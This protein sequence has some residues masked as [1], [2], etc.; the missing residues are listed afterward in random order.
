[1][2]SAMML[3]AACLAFAIGWLPQAAAGLLEDFND[4]RQAFRS[5]DPVGLKS[6]SERLHDTPLAIYARYWPLAIELTRPAADV[7]LDEAGLREFFRDY[8]S[9]WLSDRLR[10]DYAKRLAR[11]GRW[12]EFRRESALVV[13]GDD[14]IN[15]YRLQQRISNNEASAL[16]EAQQLWFTGKQLPEACNPVFDTLLARQLLTREK[17]WR[18]IQLAMD[19]NQFG[20]AQYLNRIFPAGQGFD[21][22]QMTDAINK[23]AAVLEK[24][25]GSVSTR[26]QQEIALAAVGRLAR[27]DPVRAASALQSLAPELS[28][29]QQ[30]SGWGRVGFYGARKH[31][32]AALGWFGRA[33]LA[34]LVD[35]EREW[36]VRAA[37]RGYQWDTVIAV[38]RAMSPAEQADPPWRYWL[39]RALKI[40]GQ[41]VEANKLLAPLSLEHHFYGLLAREELDAVIDPP[42]T[43][44]Q[45]N[46][47]E[48]EA[49]AAQPNVQRA[50][51]LFRIEA[52]AEAVKEWNWATRKLD[53]RQ[54]IAAAELARRE[55]WYDRAIYAADRT[56]FVHDFS[57]RYLAPYRDVTRVYAA[58]VNLDDAWVYGLIRQESRFVT[59][60][61][62]GVGASG[63]MQ[64]M[65]TTAAWVARKLGLRDY[66]P[67]SVNE[68]GTNVKLGTYYLRTVLDQLGSQPVLAT[69][70]Y[71][72]GPGRARAWQADAALEG[73]IYAETI[74]FSETRDYVKKVMANAQ[75]YAMVFGSSKQTLKQRLGTIPAK[76]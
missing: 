6:A 13:E 46:D 43:R 18:R 44:H 75:F 67:G 24:L 52:R 66:T 48:V 7:T 74:P 12:S 28:A 69:A 64:L 61:R 2:A 27:T 54:L 56:R 11:S 51:A 76:P 15:C 34:Q 16:K 25:T 30:A 23:P 47:A 36:Y 58:Q 68:I 38:I 65:P 53:D 14:E 39:A 3:R 60:A 1:M 40:Q 62:S 33:D 5:R 8:P 41:P 57:L 55:G 35:D 32:P 21:N 37:L 29:A 73:A 49:I 70:A 10:L 71:N 17:V 22:R 4:G 72:A 19:A 26:P 63:L 20:L 9:D 45:L 31:D 42:Q 50:L 59:Q